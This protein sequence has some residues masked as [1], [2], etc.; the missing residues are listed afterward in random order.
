MR[1]AWNISVKGSPPFC[2]VQRVKS[3]KWALKK[4]NRDSFGSVQSK[5][6]LLYSRLEYL[7]GLDFSEH[8]WEAEEVCKPSCLR[9]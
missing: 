5:I 2:L 4:W 3:T 1:E 6:L 8:N 7:Q 9:C